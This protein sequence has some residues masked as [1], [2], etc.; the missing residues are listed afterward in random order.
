MSDLQSSR[1]PTP[2]GELAADGEETDTLQRRPQRTSVIALPGGYR[3]LDRPQVNLKAIKQLSKW[4][5]RF[6]Y[7]ALQ[8]DPMY[9]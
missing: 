4:G 9:V 1:T 2:T 3:Q 6:V 7:N 5:R 8:M